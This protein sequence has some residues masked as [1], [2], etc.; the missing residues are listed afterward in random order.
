MACRQK[1]KLQNE[2]VH[3]EIIEISVPQKYFG[4]W[5]KLTISK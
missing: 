3:F 5:I 2:H 4:Q 1:A